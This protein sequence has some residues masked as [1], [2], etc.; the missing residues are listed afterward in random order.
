MD[1]SLVLARLRAITY[2]SGRAH[3]ALS[4]GDTETYSEELI[5]IEQFIADIHA[6]N[7]INQEIIKKPAEEE[8]D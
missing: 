7:E 8:S 4:H 1:R 6:K 5:N 3:V 2:A